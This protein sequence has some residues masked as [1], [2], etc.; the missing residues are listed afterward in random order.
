MSSSRAARALT[1]RID[2][3][4]DPKAMAISDDGG[5]TWEKVLFIDDKTGVI[6]LVVNPVNPDVLYAATYEKVRTAWTY[7][8][9]GV[10]SRIHKSTDGGKSW[11][12]L[13]GGLL[14]WRRK[15]ILH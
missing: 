10:K 3:V 12:V 8:P 2:V 6:D 11:Q 14:R 4:R 5:K 1:A 9:G 7:E 15:R 13:S